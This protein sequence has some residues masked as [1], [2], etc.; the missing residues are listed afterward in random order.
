MIECFYEDGI[1]LLNCYDDN[2]SLIVK[3]LGDILYEE[4]PKK[5]RPI[6]PIKLDLNKV[7]AETTN[8]QKM[9]FSNPDTGKA[10]GGSVIGN[11]LDEDDDLVVFLDSLGSNYTTFQAELNYEDQKATPYINKKGKISL[12]T[13][14]FDRVYRY[15]KEYI[16]PNFGIKD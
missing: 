8:L 3:T 1:I 5:E 16:I 13:D 6:Y 9:Y 14:D 7:R 15:I 10:T 2:K 12:I 11:Y 4:I